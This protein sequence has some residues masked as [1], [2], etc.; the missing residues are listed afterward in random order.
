MVF[1][2]KGAVMPIAAFGLFGWCMANGAGI[3]AIS[4]PLAVESSVPFGWAFLSGI[5][6]VIGISAALIVSQPD[7]SSKSLEDDTS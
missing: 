1:S 5:N 6:S 4:N 2:V 7:M 3:S